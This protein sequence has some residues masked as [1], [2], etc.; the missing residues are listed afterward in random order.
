MK[1][2]TLFF[3]VFLSVALFF[4]WKEKEEDKADAGP[5][6]AQ[7]P[8]FPRLLKDKVKSVRIDNIERSVQV[9]LERDAF[10]SWFMTDP[11][12]Y[13]AVAR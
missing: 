10:G 7:Y 8:L 12:P 3:L 6:L 2:G 4:L 9:K 13:P 1:K 11:L 5:Q